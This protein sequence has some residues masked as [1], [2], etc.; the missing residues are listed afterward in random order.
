MPARLPA[1]SL[2]GR[3]VGK[4][5][6]PSA[7]PKALVAGG[8]AVAF[9][10]G[11]AG[12][13]SASAPSS[14]WDRLARC[15]AG[16]NWSTNTGNSYYGGLQ[17]DLATWRSVGGT[18]RPDQA[19]RSEQIRRANLLHDARGFSPWPSCSRRLGLRSGPADVEREQPP[20]ARETQ[21]D[22]AQEAETDTSRSRVRASRSRRAQTPAAAPAASRARA[23]V[24]LA[25]VAPP[26]FDGR[27]MTAADRDVYR[28][29]TERWQRRMAAR[30]W[31]IAVD[32]R[33]G[34]QSAA[35]AQRFAAQKGLQPAAA[36][37]VDREVWDGAWT[38]SVD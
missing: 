28:L 2:F 6:K 5:A 14:E 22:D 4:H 7:A 19:G 36:A 32:G 29:S 27:V 10:L 20:A 33:F 34:P 16:G 21:R 12:S 24:A 13:A 31:D 30:G 1:R 38:L 26:A 37:S 9:L 15:E 8:A 35:V 17:F 18:G 3:S 11:D 25:A 23:V